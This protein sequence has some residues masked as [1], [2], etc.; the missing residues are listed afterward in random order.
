MPTFLHVGCGPKHKDK[1]VA[2]FQGDDWKE[3]RLDID[4][5]VEP[6]I[7][8][9]ML[10]M[11]AVK[12]ASVDA[13]Y[14]SHNIQHLYPHEIPVALQEFLRVLKPKGFLLLTCPDLQTVA[15]LVAEDKLTEE[16]Y[17]SPAGPIAPIDMLY[18]YR[19]QLAAGNLNLANKCGFTLRVLIA[20]IKVAGFMA[21][22]GKRRE[23][24]FD[25]WVVASK[26]NLTDKKIRKLAEDFLPR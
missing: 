21:V 7:V 10:D 6:D 19:P 2:G 22:A 15:K 1:T 25:L 9:S 17:T 20:T 12:S 8:G 5:S 23:P 3:I 24:A 26:A 16:A 11:S 13:V 4:P 14:S 18:G